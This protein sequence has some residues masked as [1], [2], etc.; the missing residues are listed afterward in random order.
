MDDAPGLE[1]HAG[2]GLHEGAK[3]FVA[4]NATNFPRGT[5][6]GT[7]TVGLSDSEECTTEAYDNALKHAPKEPVA[8]AINE[9]GMIEGAN[10]YGWFNQ[11]IR[12]LERN[13]TLPISIQYRYA[14]IMSG[15]KELMVSDVAELSNGVALDYGLAVYVLGANEEL[16]GCASLKTLDEATAAEYD[17]VVH[18]G[19]CPPGA[20]E[21]EPSSASKNG[22]FVIVSAIAAVGIAFVWGDILAL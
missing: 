16:L 19:F 22:M 14:L 15:V 7:L 8:F 21:E 9:L 17:K 6:N 1:G 11:T 18:G 4:T 13:S 5:L 10:Q 20:I 3:L 2:L 12:E